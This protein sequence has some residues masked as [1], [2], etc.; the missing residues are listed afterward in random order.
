MRTSAELRAGFR[1][2]YES[3]GHVFRPSA[4]LVPRADDRSTLLTTA[5]MQPLMPYFL[6][7]EAPPAPLLTTV[8]KCFRTQDIDEVGLDGSHLTFFEMLGNFSFGQY[9]KEGAIDFAWEFVFD[10]LKID[11]ERFW[12]SVFAGDPELGL[13]E[14]TVAYDHWVKIGQPTERIVFLPR[15]ENFWSVGGPGPCGP[16]TEMYYDWGEEHGCGEPDCQPSCTRCERFLEF[17]NLVFM[18]FELHVDGKL[19]PLPKENVDTGMGVD[20]LLREGRQLAVDVELEL[21]ED[22]IPELQEALAARAAR[23]AVR[24]PA[25]VLLAPVVVHLGVGTAWAR[26]TDGPEV[27]C[28][29]QE[30][31]A[32]GG[33]PD[34]HPVVVSNRVFAE[35]E[36]RIA[37]ED[38]HPETLRVDLQMVEDELPRKID[39]SFLEVLPERE[40]AEH[41]EEGQVRAVEADLVDVLRPEAFLD[42]RQQRRRRSLAPEEIGHER[43]HSCSR[44]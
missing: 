14:D 9:F 29:R 23:L 21:H 18:E 19:T 26:T 36:L 11:P 35:P 43:L 12:V 40:V 17:W 39:R 1:A 24:L 4:S 8:Q 33:L 37:C 30:D 2:F 27:L 41:L 20:V 25:A 13:G 28:A 5:G 42:G 32:L 10:H 44:Q 22:E 7:R 15:A 38:T 6:G 16:D 3:K 34:L 31:N